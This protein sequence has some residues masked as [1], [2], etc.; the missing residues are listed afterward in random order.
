MADGFLDEWKD[1]EFVAIPQGR[2][3]IR[4]PGGRDTFYVAVDITNPAVAAAMS[5]SPD[6]PA[7]CHIW[8]GQAGGANFDLRYTHL[9]QLSDESV[10]GPD[11]SVRRCAWQASPDGRR[12]T[13][14]FEFYLGAI[15]VRKAGETPSEQALRLGDLALRLTL[16]DP[17]LGT[18]DLIGS[19]HLGA[20]GFV[21]VLLP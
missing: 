4:R 3:A 8:A 15:P 19:S 16:D 12:G 13:L 18:V 7:A 11:K 21:R 6:L 5:A 20:L 2:L 10:M 14:E 9:A 17:Q 1:E